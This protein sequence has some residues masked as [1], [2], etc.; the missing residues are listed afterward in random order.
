MLFILSVVSIVFVFVINC[1]RNTMSQVD[2]FHAGA[3]QSVE[4]FATVDEQNNTG[5]CVHD[6]QVIHI[7][8]ANCL[9]EV[10]LRKILLHH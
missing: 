8:I 6:A 7:C 1:S 4:I 2:I 9:D 10:N 5:M 3:S